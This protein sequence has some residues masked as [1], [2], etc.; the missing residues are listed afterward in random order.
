MSL[1]SAPWSTAGSLGK[2]CCEAI[3]SATATGG[4]ASSTASSATTTRAAP[5][6]D[7]EY[8]DSPTAQ[9]SRRCGR[10]P[11]TV[12][13]EVHPVALRP[14]VDRWGPSPGPSDDCPSRCAIPSES[15]G[16]D[17][18]GCAADAMTVRRLG[19]TPQS[20]WSG[21]GCGLLVRPMSRRA[22][23]PGTRC[24]L[25]RDRERRRCGRIPVAAG[26]PAAV[27]SR[28]GRPCRQRASTAHRP[29]CAHDR[30]GLSPDGSRWT[31]TLRRW[32]SGPRCG[33]CR[34]TLVRVDEASVGR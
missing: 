28:R 20:R 34:R 33:V 4:T 3:I 15:N 32:W 29:R 7:I 30:V 27:G 25:G 24:L 11:P 9:N 2:G 12:A 13:C 16:R 23:S 26:D 18:R 8:G 31:A 6:P 19:W 21:C 5:D 14:H 10:P 17:R 1:S 22:P